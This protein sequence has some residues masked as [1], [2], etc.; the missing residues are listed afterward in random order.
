MVALMTV[1]SLSD[2]DLMQQIRQSEA[3]AAEGDVVSLDELRGR[4]DSKPRA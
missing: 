1:G 3:A 2:P 4:P